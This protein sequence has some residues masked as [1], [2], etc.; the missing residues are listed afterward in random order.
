MTADKSHLQPSSERGGGQTCRGRAG[1][2]VPG[3][4]LLADKL[5]MW[6][7]FNQRVHSPSPM[8]LLLGSDLDRPADDG[9]SPG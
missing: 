7:K 1:R 9:D 5:L 3:A 4:L 2:A 8:L 6:S